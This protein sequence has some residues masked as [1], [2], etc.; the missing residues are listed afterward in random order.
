MDNQR[1]SIKII[2]DNK[3]LE[4][5]IKMEMMMKRMI[6]LLPEYL[7]IAA[8]KSLVMRKNKIIIIILMMNKN[9]KDRLFFY[10]YL[11]M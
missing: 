7:I 10:T 11:Y 1:V 8:R 5:K 4:I 9:I 3:I 2:M 6:T